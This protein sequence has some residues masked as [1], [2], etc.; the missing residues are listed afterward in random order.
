M[1]CGRRTKAFST[2]N[3]EP[4]VGFRLRDSW[5]T[6]LLQA[7]KISID[8]AE[9]LYTLCGNNLEYHFNNLAVLRAR[10]E[11]VLIDA[12]I[13]ATMGH[14][15]AVMKPIR[16][17]PVAQL[18]EGQF[19]IALDRRRI[20][21]VEGPSM[22]GKTMWVR[23]WTEAVGGQLLELNCAGDMS[24]PSLRKFRFGTHTHVLLEEASPACVLDNRKLWQGGPVRVQLGQSA[25]NK[26]E[27]A[28]CLHNVRIAVTSN[29]WAS[30]VAVLSDEDRSW[31]ATNVLYLYE[32]LRMWSEAGD[33]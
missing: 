20:L 15:R 16:H 6:M 26:F 12:S 10:Q 1:I 14:L 21:V 9:R 4:G 25:T 11:D 7:Q 22:V 2:G 30:R 8:E 27:Y 28:V 33:A 19:G 13:A 17:Y 18:W 23:L 5:I 3:V 29:D 32:P 31:L 24:T